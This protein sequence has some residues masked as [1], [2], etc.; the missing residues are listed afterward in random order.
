MI[1]L[2]S[3]ITITVIIII[4]I[5]TTAATAILSAIKAQAQVHD[6]KQLIAKISALAPKTSQTQSK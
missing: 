6:T 1:L 3:T 2:I 5:T 4:I